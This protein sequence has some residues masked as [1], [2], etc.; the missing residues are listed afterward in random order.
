MKRR[1]IIAGLVLC[2]GVASAG[3]LRAEVCPGASPTPSPYDPIPN[4]TKVSLGQLRSALAVYYGDTE[5]T[6][7][8]TLDKL[9]PKYIP[10][11][12]VCVTNLGTKSGVQNYTSSVLKGSDLDLTKI[13][14]TGKW[15]YSKTEGYIFVD[16]KFAQT[17]Y[18][19]DSSSNVAYLGQLRSAL[20]IYYGDNEAY[21]A[22][23]SLL[24]PKYWAGSL[25]P[26]TTCASGIKNTVVNYPHSP[27]S[28][29][30]LKSMGGNRGGWGYVPSESNVFI[31]S[32][33]NNLFLK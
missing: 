2:L 29:S 17:L 19:P 31:D 13:L 14:G 30:D 23:L 5:G 27:K 7:P 28:V 1:S 6:N 21:P 15:G 10:S 26:V 18:P 3:F 24:V 20:S 25:P 8:D 4:A 12:P 11:I 9:V 16:I 33:E 32:V 22:N